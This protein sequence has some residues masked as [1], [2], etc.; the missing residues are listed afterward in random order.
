[1][2][3]YLRMPG[4]SADSDA[5]ALE[6]W[7]V[8]KGDT[9]AAGDTVASVETEKAVVDIE[10]DEESVIYAL[11]AESGSMVAVGDP[12]AVLIAPARTRRGG[13]S[14]RPTRWGS[15][16]RAAL[17][18][19]RPGGVERLGFGAV[20]GP[21][22]GARGPGRRRRGGGGRGPGRPRRRAG[23][24]ACGDRDGR[25]PRL[26]RRVRPDL[27]E[28]ARAPRGGRSGRGSVERPGRGRAAASC[29]PMSRPQR[30]P[31][32][33]LRPRRPPPLRRRPPLR[34]PPPRRCRRA[35]RPLR[36]RSCGV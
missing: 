6:F 10:I 28:P 35:G 24:C 32:S 1:M 27:R 18:R 3:R 5:A 23:R 33:Q 19:P 36:T 26:R 11:V 14:A 31:R 17:H 15:G 4:V 7:T 34:P 30:P 21:P 9:V 2:A 13:G 16:R 20:G 22:R 8:E 25:G 12:I 29:A